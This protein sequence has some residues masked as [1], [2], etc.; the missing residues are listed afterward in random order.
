MFC[1]YNNTFIALH[2]SD[3]YQIKVMGKA[4]RHH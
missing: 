4:F 1:N 2:S 3:P